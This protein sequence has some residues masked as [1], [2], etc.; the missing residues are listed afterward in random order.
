MSSLMGRAPLSGGGSIVPPFHCENGTDNCDILL[1]IIFIRAPP[2]AALMQKSPS[3][4]GFVSVPAFVNDIAPS[5]ARRLYENL[6]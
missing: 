5:E 1:N 3:I 4:E 6:A 2:S